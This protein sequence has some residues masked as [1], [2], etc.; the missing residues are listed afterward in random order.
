MAEM[1][2]YTTEGKQMDPVSMKELK[3]LVGDG[4][5]KPTDMVWKEGMARWI[6]ASSVKELFPDPISAL[7]HYF[8]T[9]QEAPK[10]DAGPTSVTPAVAAANVP[11]PAKKSEPEPEEEEEAPR[12]KRRRSSED[13]DD[14]D[15]SRPPRRRS[16]SSGGRGSNVGIIIGVVVFIV[17]MLIGCG[18]GFAILLMVGPFAPQPGQ[19]I[20]GQVN[21]N[22][23][24][25]PNGVESRT[26]IFRKGVDYE[27]TVRSQPRQPDVD[28]FIINGRT[29]QIAAFDDSVG[30]DS[31]IARW[32]PFET[33]DF[34]VEVRNLHDFTHVTSTVNIRELPA[35]QPPPP[36][37]PKD[38]V[39]GKDGQPPLPPDV[40]EGKGF[41]EVPLIS[42]GKDKI[43]KFRVRAGHKVNFRV[44]PSA[45]RPNVNLDLFVLR[46]T[47]G[48]MIASDS[49]LDASAQVDFTPQI[50]EVVRVRIFNAG[51]G[52]NTSTQAKLFFDVSP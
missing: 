35:N 1:W 4:T 10:R 40:T 16:D 24:V 29:G 36:P 31:N 13:D 51:A 20:N 37:P 22:V 3:R 6:R 19:P 38:K 23:G 39:D 15:T 14:R 41:I 27:I 17:V 25:R 33:G 32:S 48:A 42:T 43:Y 49:K 7:D 44:V 8:S 47:D 46:D 30:P 12:K 26:F 52:P 45:K 2:Y 34:R 5:L 50:T 21:Y 18:G 9:G 11:A 28:L